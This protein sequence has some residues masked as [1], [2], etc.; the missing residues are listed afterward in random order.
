[1]ITE[2]MN[3]SIDSMIDE[4]FGDKIEKAIETAK[5]A[6]ATADEVLKDLPKC[7]DDSKREDRPAQISEIPKVDMDGKRDGDY[8]QDI[9][10]KQKEEESKEVKDQSNA[11]VLNKSEKE[12]LELLRKEKM[13]REK[14]IKKAET[15]RERDELIKA[16]VE[17]TT[18]QTSLKYD[19]I[20]NEMKKA[21]EDLKKTNEDQSKLIKSFAKIP[22]KPKSITSIEALEKSANVSSKSEFFSKSEIMDVAESLVKSK[23]LKAEHLI[24]LENCGNIFDTE[25]KS[26]LENE[27]MKK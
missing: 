18:T 25:A 20:V 8:D 2:E 17:K 9:T 13:E 10:E 22:S 7:E 23:K 24:E 19:T 15:E 14:E 4:L 16:I 27:L 3:K 11:V 1:M 26:I 12:E 6:K 21:I 5:D